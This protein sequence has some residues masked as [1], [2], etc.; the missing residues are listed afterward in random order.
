MASYKLEIPLPA[1][2]DSEAFANTLKTILATTAFQLEAQ[3]A[4]GTGNDVCYM[5][6]LC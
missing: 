4:P 2:K 6:E 3:T 5:R 1:P